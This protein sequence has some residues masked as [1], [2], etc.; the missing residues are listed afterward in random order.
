MN[1]NENTGSAESITI[2]EADLHLALHRRAVVEMMDRYAAD[3]MGD[4]KPLSES[5]KERLIPG[6]RTHPGTLVFLAMNGDEPA[7]VAVCFYGFS[8]FKALPFV[9][10][11]DYFVRPDL[12]GRGVG[13]GLL[14]AVE[15]KAAETGCCKLTLE[16]QEFNHRARQVYESFGFS[17]SVY[18]EEAGGSLH[19]SKPLP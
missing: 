15:K 19:L 13:R 18:T 9:H 1:A 2:L 8:T 12:R 14:A 3:P 7:G 16:V 4:G 6:M 10:V 17:Q 11:S 5:V